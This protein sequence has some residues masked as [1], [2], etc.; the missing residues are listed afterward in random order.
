MEIRFAIRAVILGLSGLGEQSVLSV[1]ELLDISSALSIQRW[2]NPSACIRV[3]LQ[4]HPEKK[5]MDLFL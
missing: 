4:Y 2:L 1:L 3:N 5:D